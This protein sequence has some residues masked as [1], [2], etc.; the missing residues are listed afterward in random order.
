MLLILAAFL[1]F[2]GLESGVV[3][4]ELIQGETVQTSQP[5]SSQP[6]SLEDAIQMAL[7][8]NP[9]IRA[10]QQDLVQIVA[11]RHAAAGVASTSTTVDR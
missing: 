1:A 8:N 11:P 2:R 5:R 9:Q 6:L 7:E 10:D 4:A 3:R